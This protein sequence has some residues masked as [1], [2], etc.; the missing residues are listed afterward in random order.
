MELLK[1]DNS[2]VKLNVVTGLKKI[3][4]VVGD[5]LFSSPMLL[6]VLGNMTK[7]GQWRVRMSVFELLADFAIIFGMETYTTH[8]QTIFMGY[9]TNTAAS[10]RQMGITKSGILAAAFKNEWVMNEYIPVVINHFSLDKKG[11]NYRMCCLNSL[12]AV[13][14]YV[15]KD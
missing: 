5:E 7:D 10:V 11:Y 3:A 8:L 1:D 9:L 15:M 6:T 13:L 4:H 14:P 12:A 2:E